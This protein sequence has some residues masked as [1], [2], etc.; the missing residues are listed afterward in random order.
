M[1]CF[2]NSSGSLEI[3]GAIC[4]ARGAEFG[5]FRAAGPILQ[6]LIEEHFQRG[7]RHLRETLGD[8]GGDT[9]LHLLCG[10]LWIGGESGGVGSGIDL[11]TVIDGLVA[12]LDQPLYMVA[13]A[14]EETMRLA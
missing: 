10:G 6:A 14:G 2:L 4:L 13:K 1:Y 11:D 12:V 5:L 9:I 3:S 8:A 7:N